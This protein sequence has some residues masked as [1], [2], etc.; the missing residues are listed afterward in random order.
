MVDSL[1]RALPAITLLGVVLVLAACNR[2][3]PRNTAFDAYHGAYAFGDGDVVVFTQSGNDC[4]R[5]VHF[6]GRAG[7]VCADEDLAPSTFVGANYLDGDGPD[8]VT[9]TFSD[10]RGASVE[11]SREDGQSQ[12]AER[13]PVTAIDAEFTSQGTQL[14]GRLLIPPGD[15]P[16]PLVVFAHGSS[17]RAAIPGY[18]EQ[19]FLAAN[20][21]ATFVFDKRGTGLSGGDYTQDFDLLATDVAAG[22]GEA[23]SLLGDRLGR[24]GLMGFS[25]GGWVAPL[26]ATETPVDFLIV[27]YGLAVSPAEEERSE[28]MQQMRRAGHDDATV[29]AAGALADAAITLA[30]SDFAVGQEEFA[31][32]KAQAAADGWLSDIAEDNLTAAL[33]QNPVWMVNLVWPLF[34]VDT[35]WRH[36]PVPIIQSLDIPQLWVLGGGDTEAPSEQTVAILSALQRD[37]NRGIVTAV[38][39]T[40]D[41]GMIES[42]GPDAGNRIVDGYYLL[43]IDFIHGW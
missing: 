28:I 27:A 4:L 22:V 31:G 16:V 24:T 36:E 6:D 30:D 8:A 26:A 21:I 42:D 37:T 20:N 23:Q 35:P 7:R 10:P 1:S 33:G 17:Q 5:Y 25:Q 9:V 18:R 34:D 3:E 15:D 19:H 14:V 38:F 11:F 2:S 29:A 13:V 40:A 32:L 39:P 12:S 41:H 43:V